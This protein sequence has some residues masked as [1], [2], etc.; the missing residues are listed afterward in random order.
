MVGQAGRLGAQLTKALGLKPACPVPT[1]R[2]G[3]TTRRARGEQNTVTL[4]ATKLAS[5]ELPPF[6]QLGQPRGLSSGQPVGS[7]SDQPAGS[8]SDQPAAC[9]NVFL[10]NGRYP[11]GLYFDTDGELMFFVDSSGNESEIS[12]AAN[13]DEAGTGDSI[14]GVGNSQGSAAMVTD[15]GM[16]CGANSGG[17]A[18]TADGIGA[19]TVNDGSGGGARGGTSKIP[20]QHMRFESRPVMPGL[21][22]SLAGSSGP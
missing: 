3:P 21:G 2:V 12:D 17:G 18:A 15:A 13:S 6:G 7:S 22:A 5:L 9:R 10:Q 14:I 19:K 20:R 1:T 16:D 4:R 8:S 11:N